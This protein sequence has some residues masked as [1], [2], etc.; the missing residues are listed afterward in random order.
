MRQILDDEINVFFLSF[1][2]VQRFFAQQQ[3]ERLKE[4][5][6]LER[7]NK[8]V[9]RVDYVNEMLKLLM[10][11]TLLMMVPSSHAQTQTQ[12]HLATA[13]GSK[14]STHYTTLRYAISSST[15]R[16]CSSWRFAGAFACCCAR[17]HTTRRRRRRRDD[18]GQGRRV[19]W[20]LRRA[21]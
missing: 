17:R 9:N 16:P 7:K 11:K 10:L 6:S 12:T 15:L 4:T 13:T 18:Q 2:E 14:G 21:L 5:Q 20:H 19:S 3:K 1:N 8:G